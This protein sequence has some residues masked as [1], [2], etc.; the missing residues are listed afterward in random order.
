MSQ[1]QDEAYTEACQEIDRLKALCAR[2]AEALEA[3]P[4]GSG[5]NLVLIDE[6]RE[7]AQ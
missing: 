3:Y 2:A 6:L 1:I 7:A 4:V 5:W